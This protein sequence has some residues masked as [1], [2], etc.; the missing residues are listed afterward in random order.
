MRYRF[1]I[2]VGRDIRWILNFLFHDMIMSEAQKKS[3]WEQIYTQ[4]LRGLSINVRCFEGANH[5]TSAVFSACAVAAKD[6]PF[7]EQKR[8]IKAFSVSQMVRICERL[9]WCASGV[10]VVCKAMV[11]WN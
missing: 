11:Q 6:F 1:G 8:Q 3:V 5:L 10:L 7:L 9:C 4:K 2:R